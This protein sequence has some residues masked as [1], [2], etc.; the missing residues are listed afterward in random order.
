VDLE[1]LYVGEKWWPSIARAIEAADVFVFLMTPSSLS[2]KACSE[3]LNEAEK[4]GKRII[5]VAR[6]RVEAERALPEILASTQWLIAYDEPKSER[7][8]KALLATLDLD[9]NWL[10]GHTRWLQLALDWER[11]DRSPELLLRGAVIDEA[12]AW[13]DSPPARPDPAIVPVQ[14]AFISA[15]QEANLLAHARVLLGNGR[16]VDALKAAVSAAR[17]SNGDDKQMPP[18]TFSTLCACTQRVR[19]VFPLRSIP[20]GLAVC[21]DA[22]RLATIGKNSGYLWDATGQLPANT[23]R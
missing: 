3:E 16:D 22:S 9:S 1:G 5:P 20:N 14:K 7:W 15:S 18:S 8:R 13:L 12:V 23:R 10:R 6:Q 4:L 19:G 17:F 21:P 11:R 2:S